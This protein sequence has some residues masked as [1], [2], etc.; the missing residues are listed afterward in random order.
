[1]VWFLEISI[2]NRFYR[3]TI[4]V[5]VLQLSYLEF[6]NLEKFILQIS[7]PLLN[8]F[9][10]SF[11]LYFLVMSAFSS[12]DDDDIGPRFPVKR[13]RAVPD[14]SALL[15]SLNLPTA[16]MY[17]NSFMHKC[18]V[19]RVLASTSTNFVITVSNADGIVKFWKKAPIGIEFV[20]TVA[21]G[22]VIIDSALMPDGREFALIATDQT[23]RLFDVALFTLMSIT[24]LSDTIVK[25][26]PLASSI[27]LCTAGGPITIPGRP[28]FTMHTHPVA[29]IQYHLS[30]MVSIDT[31][32]FIEVWCPS[33]LKSAVKSK[34]DTDLFALK[35][36]KTTSL[37]LAI[38]TDVFAVMTVDLDILI[39]N[40]NT[41]RIIKRMNLGSEKKIPDQIV[42]MCFAGKILIAPS[43][44]GIHMFDLDDGPLAVLGKVET[45]ERFLDVCLFQGESLRESKL[46]TGEGGNEDFFDPTIIATALGK[47]RFYL[48]SNR[49]PKESRDVFNEEIVKNASK[50]PSV[51][52]AAPTRATLNTTMGDIQLS[53]LPLL[54]PKAVENFVTLAKSGYFDGTV[55]HRVVKG[56]MIQT[57]DPEG[58]GGESI[59]GKG[60]PDE[61]SS[62]A[63]FNKPFVLAMANYGPGT[64]GSQFFITTVPTPWLDGKH[65]IFGSVV[66][67]FDVVTR[68]ENLETGQDDRPK[69]DVKILT[70]RL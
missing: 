48:F 6:R 34:L 43:S 40:I 51:S 17:E 52:F 45:S 50:L 54:A 65:T 25:I 13:A 12:S 3:V 5:G 23:L 18:P 24:K 32:G 8:D 46:L 35:K 67:G 53:L 16:E 26:C 49:L 30:L 28:P 42:G 39:F 60:F 1:M 29:H 55:F 57:G 4:W 63:K 47:P 9:S 68:I 58:T 2:S 64:N 22:S 38:G 37:A 33:T 69:D 21:C 44:L 66:D 19:S 20:K 36:A 41:C 7:F 56:F 31:A 59:W 14:S 62:H 15:R 11:S 61:I 10:C 27:A 70:I